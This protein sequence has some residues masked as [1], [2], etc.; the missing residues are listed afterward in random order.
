[1]VSLRIAKAADD[2]AIRHLDQ[3][4][5]LPPNRDVEQLLQALRP[6]VRAWSGWEFI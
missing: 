2:R 5:L 4:G 6:R 1:M 3:H